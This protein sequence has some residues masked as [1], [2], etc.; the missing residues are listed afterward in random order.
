M[1]KQKWDDCIKNSSHPLIYATSVYLDCM[2]DNWDGLILNDYEAVMPLPWR[3]KFFIKYIYTPAFIQQLGIFS[4]LSLNENIIHTF[5]KNIPGDFKYAEINCHSCMKMQD[6]PAQEGKNYLLNISDSYEE[7]KKNYSRSAIRNISKAGANNV[8]I[9][10][11]VDSNLIIQL[12]QKRFNNDIGVTQKDYAKFSLLA[13]GLTTKNACYTFGAFVRQQ[14]IAGSIYFLYENR[15]VFIFNGNSKES[16]LNGAT[17]LLKDEAIKFFANKVEYM[18]FEGS[19][20]PDF[21][22]FYQQYGAKNYEVYSKIR[23]NRLPK[24]LRL[25]KR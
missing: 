9:K 16:L 18:D 5:F 23:I 14:L 17:H 13:E 10:Q 12:H 3:K 2:A 1:D 7:I 11:D 20:N 19:N 24:L 6:W 8:S 21:A 4:N 22:R 25:F 15:V